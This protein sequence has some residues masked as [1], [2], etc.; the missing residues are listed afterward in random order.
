MSSRNGR[1]SENERQ[2][3]SEIYR[4]LKDC[5]AS[6]RSGD[7][8]FE[9]LESKA[10]KRL[11]SAGFSPDYFNIRNKSTLQPASATESADDWVVLVAAHLGD[12]RLIDT[13]IGPPRQRGKP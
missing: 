6:L 1:L 10:K 2:Q 12:V 7:Q 5:V 11:S 13:N 4:T 9:A 3:A 8:N